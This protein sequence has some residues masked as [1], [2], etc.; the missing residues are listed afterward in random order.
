MRTRVLIYCTSTSIIGTKVGVKVPV[1]KAAQVKS[2][3]CK[4]YSITFKHK[5][6]LCLFWLM[7]T[8]RID[9]NI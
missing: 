7:Q 9:I 2:N 1:Q 5:G 8:G 4:R 3:T 6:A